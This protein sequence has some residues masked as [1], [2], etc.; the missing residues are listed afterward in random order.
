[1]DSRKF[2]F[3]LRDWLNARY[4]TTTVSSR[5]IAIRLDFK[6][7][8]TEVTPGCKRRGGGY[9]IPDGKGGWL[10]TNPPFHTRLMKEADAQHQGKLKPLVRLMKIWNMTH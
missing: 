4:A 7:F 9:Y 3:W 10:S 8:A 5:K 1:T 6:T 2:V